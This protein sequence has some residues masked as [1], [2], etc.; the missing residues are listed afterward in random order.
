M[1]LLPSNKLTQEG[2]IL[3]TLPAEFTLNSN[4]T[5]IP[6]TLKNID[7]TQ[8]QCVANTTSNKFLVRQLFFSFGY[9]PKVDGPISF[10][11]TNI[12]A[13]NPNQTLSG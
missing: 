13:A 7:A 2:R 1:T 6:T 10:N 12:I 4:S 9:L 8:I 3:V 11:L 5:V